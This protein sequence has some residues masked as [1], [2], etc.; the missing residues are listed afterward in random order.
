MNANPLEVQ[1]QI[2]HHSNNMG[3]NVK[4]LYDWED[5]IKEMEKRQKS[6]V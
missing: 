1:A 6:Q 2:M 3:D 5:E 4:G